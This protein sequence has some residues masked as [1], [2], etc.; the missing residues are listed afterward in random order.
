MYS[1]PSG[2][3]RK[4]GP[5]SEAIVAGYRPQQQDVHTRRD[6]AIIQLSSRSSTGGRNRSVESVLIFARRTSETHCRLRRLRRDRRRVPRLA[7]LVRRQHSEAA[8]AAIAG[9]PQFRIVSPATSA[10][11]ITCMSCSS[12]PTAS[13]TTQI[14][15]M[16]MS[17]RSG[18]RPR[19]NRSTRSCSNR[20]RTGATCRTGSCSSSA[21][22]ARP[23]RWR[24]CDRRDSTSELAH[25][26]DLLSM[27]SPQIKALVQQDPLGLLTM[28]RER[29][30]REKSMVAFDP[31]QEGY[32][33]QDGRSRLVVVKPRGAAVRHR[34][35]QAAV[36]AI[37]GGGTSGPRRASAPPIPIRRRSLSARPA[38]TA[39]RSRPSS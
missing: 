22:T 24:V 1:S 21:P 7:G 25:A 10:A 36:S 28:L 5:E 37:V 39:C 11:S 30:S 31:T 29:M 18:M 17:R 32:V 26:R 35:L 6:E 34:L 4:K 14:S 3:M 15:W 9:G 33:S 8:A 23:R 12:R 13:A 16:L 27:P 19:S 38:P 20:A 2:S